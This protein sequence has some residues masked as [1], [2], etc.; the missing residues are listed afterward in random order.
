[1]RFASPNVRFEDLVADAA[2]FDRV[3]AAGGDG[4]VSAVC[5]AMRH[6][7]VPVLVY[8]AGT[9]NLLALNLGLPL[10]APALARITLEGTPV[11]F[12]LGELHHTDT[13]GIIRS[14]GFAVMAGAGYDA[15]IM[16]SAA[17]LKATFGAAAYLMAAVG[18]IAPTVSCLRSSSMARLSRPTASPCCS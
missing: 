14:S 4:T 6:T 17:P 1:M 9:A 18:N 11:S 3:V 7:G 12:D 10:D 2:A 15:A 16:E 8:P 13:S 5:Y